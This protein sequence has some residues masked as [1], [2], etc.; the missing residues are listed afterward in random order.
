MTEKFEYS[1]KLSLKNIDDLEA[2]TSK[3]DD[4]AKRTYFVKEDKVWLLYKDLTLWQIRIIYQLGKGRIIPSYR[5]YKKPAPDQKGHSIE[6]L[7][8]F[9]V[10]YTNSN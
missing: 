8:D 6:V 4:P 9:Q 1:G 3:T 10:C 2:T 7:G 5:E